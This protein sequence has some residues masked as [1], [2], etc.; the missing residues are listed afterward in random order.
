MKTKIIKGRGKIFFYD[1]K[2]REKMNKKYPDIEFNKMNNLTFT[3]TYKGNKQFDVEIKV[4]DTKISCF[5]NKWA[6]PWKYGSKV[7]L[8]L[9]F[10][11]LKKKAITHI[12]GGIQSK[13]FK[14]F[15]YD[16]E[17]MMKDDSKLDKKVSKKTKQKVNKV[18]KLTAKQKK[19]DSYLLKKYGYKKWQQKHTDPEL[20]KEYNKLLNNP[21]K[22][23][24]MKKN[25][26]TRKT[27]GGAKKMY[28][29]NKYISD[30]TLKQLQKLSYQDLKNL[31][32]VELQKY[33]KRVG[34]IEQEHGPSFTDKELIRMLRKYT[35]TDK[36]NQKKRSKQT[37]TKTFKK[38]QKKEYYKCIKK[39][40]NP[41]SLGLG[42]KRKMKGYN[43]TIKKYLIKCNDKRS[44]ILKR[45]KKKYPKEWK[46]F[47]DNY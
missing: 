33:K 25:N 39:A 27:M 38:E 45:L 5:V 47:V 16:Y 37:N 36:T 13:L 15:R 31:S 9:Y 44:K 18:E 19:I 22:I 20:I 14:F 17:K 12:T 24:K 26:K 28:H 1:E 7:E 4:D 32:S 3:T 29:K 11:D 42:D 6:W 10:K 41:L 30:S 2:D 21:D 23:L 34:I 46:E 40:L 43:K 35:A 8:R